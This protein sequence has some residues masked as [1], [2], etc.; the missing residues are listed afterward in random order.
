MAKKKKLKF[1]KDK[2]NWPRCPYCDEDIEEVRY[3]EY[4]PTIG[5]DRF[6]LFCPHCRRIL[7]IAAQHDR[8]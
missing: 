4:D 5:K 3:K 7:N 2:T 8:I 6:V 1:V